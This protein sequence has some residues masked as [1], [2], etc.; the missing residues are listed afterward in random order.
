MFARS[1]LGD[2][3]GRALHGG[4]GHVHAAR[5]VKCGKDV[6]DDVH[7]DAKCSR[8]G[9]ILAK[10]IAVWRD[11]SVEVNSEA[12]ERSDPDSNRLNPARDKAV[13]HELLAG[14]EPRQRNQSKRKQESQRGVHDVD[15]LLHCPRV[16]HSGHDN[17]RQ[18][19]HAPRNHGP[20]P[21]W[22]LNVQKA[23]HH[24]LTRVGGGDA[25]AL[26]GGDERDSP[27]DPPAFDVKEVRKGRDSQGTGVRYGDVLVD[28]DGCQRRDRPV[29]D[30]C[31]QDWDEGVPQAELHRL[32]LVGLP[33]WA[34]PCL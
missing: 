12:A 4:E 1:A 3:Q 32:P 11:Q 13:S 29:D 27:Q 20:Q 25:G 14:R 24:E 16:Q 18:D 28:E 19:R 31:E 34:P 33:W 26:R 23:V 22:E 6:L 10:V 2:G 21:L 9:R 15:H 30:R 8:L 5:D 7:L 17:A